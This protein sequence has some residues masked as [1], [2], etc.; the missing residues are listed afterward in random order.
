M[1]GT[2]HPPLARAPLIEAVF[3]LRG[4]LEPSFSLIPG[5]I[6]A[7]LSADYPQ[8]SETELARFGTMVESPEE[9][10]L[11]ITHQYRSSD[12]K[13][14]VQLGPGGI[15][16]NS[17]AY[18]GFANFRA[19]ISAV[20]KTYFEVAVVQS[21]T[22]I[23]LRYLNRV[24][25]GDAGFLSGFTVKI[26]WPPL[27][28]GKRQAFA[29]RMLLT[30]EDPP[31]QLGAALAEPSTGATLDLDFFVQPRKAL[32]QAEILAWVDKAHDRVYEA[33]TGLVSPARFESWK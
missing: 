28:G 6:A 30:Y 5:R 26:E 7:A 4:K 15:S 16:V 17:L 20:L 1:S 11:I 12:G 22:R 18:T 32:G 25:S 2:N 14:L 27:S 31:G 8:A 23:G 19:C 10:G 9:A 29:A 21:V 13:R 24:P 33:F 3:E